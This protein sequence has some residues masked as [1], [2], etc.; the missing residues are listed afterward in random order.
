MNTNA[1]GE[2]SP[3]SSTMTDD[4]GISITLVDDEESGGEPSDNTDETNTAEEDTSTNDTQA[5]DSQDDADN[6]ATDK[7]EGEVNTKASKV[8]SSLGEDKKVFAQQL[9]ELAQTSDTNREVVANL[10]KTRPDVEKYFKSKFG[11][12]YD[13]LFSESGTGEDGTADFDVEKIRAEERAKAQ[14]DVIIQQYEKRKSAAIEE[15][16]EQ[17]GFTPEEAEEL[18][19]YVNLLGAESEFGPELLKKAG[20]VVNADKTSSKSMPSTP[21]KGDAGKPQVKKEDAINKN[22]PIL[23][24]VA[25]QIGKDPDTLV[26]NL[27]E[28]DAKRTKDGSYILNF[29]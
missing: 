27:Q 11:E 5:S 10:V 28:M 7:A 26:K 23:Q 9:I 22:D 17:N 2:V 12:D 1:S 15:Y 13:R 6:A 16:A 14:A 25:R 3:N 21:S 19:K 18:T 24:K 4:T 8:I 29:S 20:L